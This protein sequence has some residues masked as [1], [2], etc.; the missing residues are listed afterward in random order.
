VIELGNEAWIPRWV[1]DYLPAGLLET[2]PWDLFWWQWIALPAFIVAAVL[3][4][5]PLGGLSRRILSRIAARTSLAWADD[6][7]VRMGGPLRAVW[8]LILLA[9]TLPW[10]GLAAPVAARATTLLSALGLAAL[11]W[12]ILRVIDT[13]G[14][15]ARK[16]DAL[17]ADS[18]AR[19]MVSF[20]V[21]IA[22]ILVLAVAVTM[23]LS[24]L[25]YP[26][27][28]LI[29]G[30]GI[31]GLALALA[32][33]K[34]VENVFGAFSLG[35]D[36]PFRVGDFVRIEDLIGTVESIGLRS[37]RIRT[38]DRTVVAIPNGKLAE[39]RIETFAARDRIRFTTVIG[40]EYGTKVA[41]V[42]EVME[43]FERVLREHPKIWPDTVVVRFQQFGASSLDIE[44][45]AWFET[46]DFNE[47]R[48][49]RQDVL[50]KFMEVVEAAGTAFAFPTRT[51]HLVQ[52][53][54]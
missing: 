30:L 19:F 16:S 6:L 40:I 14:E 23:V 34:T 1:H 47:F 42:R 10:L 33:Q 41:Q 28:S 39:L 18:S 12:A 51:V 2:G 25:G 27:A 13:L 26:V 35:V 21:K 49:Y 50:L 20:G 7:V 36:E 43:G 3:L 52:G 29:A 11:F 37:T 45:M 38:L 15:F 54:R 9:L 17:P 48:E 22:K 53:E 4:A 8:S 24:S 32:A 44:I 46:S 5:L 31:G